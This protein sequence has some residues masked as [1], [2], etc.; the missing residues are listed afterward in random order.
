MKVT[1][2]NYKKLKEMVNQGARKGL[3]DAQIQRMITSYFCDNAEIKEPFS[4]M[5]L[6]QWWVDR[7]KK[8]MR[9]LGYKETVC[10]RGGSHGGGEIKF[11]VQNFKYFATM[12]NAI[13]PSKEFAR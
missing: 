12:Q 8:A 9:K 5:G 13:I 6:A 7:F 2:A 11:S 4:R 1:K 10:L 3:S